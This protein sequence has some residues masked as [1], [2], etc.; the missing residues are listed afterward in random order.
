MPKDDKPRGMAGK[1]GAAPAKKKA[2]KKAARR[3]PRSA[4]RQ[5]S[6][7]SGSSAIRCQPVA[8]DSASAR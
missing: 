5:S 8:F 4:S 7:G 6:T 3:P 1:R 2:A